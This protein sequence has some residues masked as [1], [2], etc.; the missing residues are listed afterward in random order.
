[1]AFTFFLIQLIRIRLSFIVSRANISVGVVR[2]RILIVINDVGHEIRLE[3]FTGT[4]NLLTERITDRRS[5][6]DITIRITR[7]RKHTGSNSS[8]FNPLLRIN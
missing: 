7:I 2:F 8:G 1:M 6:N 5:R 3:A 4:A